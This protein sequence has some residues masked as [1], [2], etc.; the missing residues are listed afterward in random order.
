MDAPHREVHPLL[1]TFEGILA[2][3]SIRASWRC[4]RSLASQFDALLAAARVHGALPESLARDRDGGGRARF[5]V[6]AQTLRVG[7]IGSRD[8]GRTT[9]LTASDLARLRHALVDRISRMAPLP[10]STGAESALDNVWATMFA[11]QALRLTEPGRAGRFPR[12]IA[13]IC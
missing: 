3:R 13:L 8:F 10:L 6:L 11:D 9:R 1:Y 7:G 5:D 4:C 2:C 12:A